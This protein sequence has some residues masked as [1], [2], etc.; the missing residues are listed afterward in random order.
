MHV[1][2]TELGAKPVLEK[3]LESQD[4]WNMGAYNRNEIINIKPQ[5]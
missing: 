2:M 3:P 1:K 5:G 4:D